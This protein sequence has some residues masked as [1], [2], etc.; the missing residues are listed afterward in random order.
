MSGKFTRFVS[1]ALVLMLVLSFAASTITAQEGKKV[2]I[3][4]NALGAS[5]V[6]TLDPSLATDTSSIQV[7]IETNPGLTRTHEIT[8]VTEPGMATW[9]VSEDGLVYTFSILPEVP[10]VKYNP[11]T[12][13]V[14]QVLDADGN[15]RYVTAEDFAFGIRRSIGGQLGSYYGGIMAGWVLNGKEV[16]DGTKPVEELGVKALDTYTL[17]ITATQPAAFL[18]SIFGMWQAYA[19]PAWVIEEAG[20]LWTEPEYFQGYGPYTLKDWVHGE[21]VTLIKNPFWPGTDT[22]PV[23]TIDE[24]K[25]LILDQS[26]SLANFEA[27]T[28]DIAQVPLADLDRIRADATLSEALYIGPSGCTYIYGINTAKPPVD[29][30]RV[31]R[32]LSMTVNRQ[33]LI[34]NVLKGGQTPAYFFSR[35]DILAAAPKAAD[36]PQYAITEDVE[37]AKALLQEY[38]DERGI[39]LEQME[40]IT[41]MHNESQGHARIAQAIQQMWTETLGI[42]VTIQTQEWGTYLETIKNEASAPQVFR[43]GWCLDYTDTHNFLYDVFHSSVRELGISWHDENAQ[44]FDQLVEQAMSEPDLQTRTDLYAEAEYL[45]TNES[46]AVIPIYFYTNLVMTQPWVER[47]YSHFGQQYYEK[48]DINLAAKP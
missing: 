25:M 28:A 39:T 35:E 36:Y 45:L 23:P 29:D 22:I 40:P 27:G 3:D 12:D 32:A 30:V 8:L 4:A 16:Y 24:I 38:L 43:Y 5:D 37:A 6:P 34:D 7:L 46:A 42:N 44:R 17:E 2:L 11:E 14:E 20:D 13:A 19:Q 33:A 10:W 31:R 1:F 41:L 9:E 48:W 21:S 15:P 18:S 26:A 47:T